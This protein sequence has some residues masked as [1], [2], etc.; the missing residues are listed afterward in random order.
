MTTTTK[1]VRVT[2]AIEAETAAVLGPVPTGK[3]RLG[4]R[5]FAGPTT[6]KTTVRRALV[7]EYSLAGLNCTEIADK[8]GVDRTTA[9]EHLNTILKEDFPEHTSALRHAWKLKNLARLEAMFAKYFKAE[10]TDGQLPDSKMGKLLVDIIKQQ[11]T[12]LG[13]NAPVRVEQSGPNGG[14]LQVENTD[15]PKFDMSLLSTEDLLKFEE[16]RAKLEGKF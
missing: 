11:T 15:V 2:K 3:K 10:I 4:P 5:A 13:H 1:P 7:L 12:M 6:A 8:L 14:P 9:Q 16:L